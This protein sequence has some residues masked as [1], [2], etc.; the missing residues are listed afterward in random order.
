MDYQDVYSK[1][2]WTNWQVSSLNFSLTE[3]VITTCFKQTAIVPVPKE[4]KVTCLNDYRPVALTSVAMK[5][6][7]RLV[8]AHINSILPDTLDTL[9]F[10]YRP[11]RST[12]YTFSIAFHTA[13]SHLDKGNTY[14]R[15]LFIDYSSAFKTIVPTTLI[16]KLRT[17]GGKCRQQ[18]VCHADL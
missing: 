9:L 16:T 1:H 17:P 13:L 14:M 3:S 7:E 18:H 8:M 4:A 6:F 2:V 15:M 11:N 10:A 5:C 12:D